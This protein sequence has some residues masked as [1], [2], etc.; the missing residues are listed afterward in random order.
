MSNERPGF[1]LDDA[2]WQLETRHFNGIQIPLYR[3]EGDVSQI[4][5]WVE[6][7]EST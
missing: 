5:G 6:N 2:G 7:P 3:S 4:K 1:V